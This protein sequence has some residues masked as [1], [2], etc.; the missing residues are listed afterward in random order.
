MIISASRRSDIP[1]YHNDAF[2]AILN[3]GS[4]TLP[5]VNSGPITI[6][7]NPTN[8]DCIV[9][10]T[11]WAKPFIQAL[12]LL[13]KLGFMYYFHYTITPYGNAYEQNIPKKIQVIEDFQELSGRIGKERIIWRYDPIIIDDYWTEERHYDTFHKMMYKLQP[14][15]EKCVISFVDI[16]SF[17]RINRTFS[18]NSVTTGDMVRI[19]K[20]F[21]D[22][23]DMYTKPLTIATC[24]EPI[25]N[26]DPRIVSNAC[27]DMRLISR[28]KEKHLIERKDAYQ[29]DGC[30]CAKSVDIGSYNTCGHGCTYCYVNRH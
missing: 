1:S 5:R 14:Y 19:S 23:A 13:D 21:A 12:D 24:C 22:I 3:M 30:N 26:S 18:A 25:L 16:Y 9:F 29:R 20:T 6:A 28:L 7:I 27:I 8:I 2:V 4:V 15:T 10:W 17:M 11:K